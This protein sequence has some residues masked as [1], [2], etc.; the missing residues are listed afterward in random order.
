MYIYK[1]AKQYNYEKTHKRKCKY[2]HRYKHIYIKIIFIGEITL[3]TILNYAPNYTLHPKLFERT[4][5]ILNYHTLHLGVTF[6]VMFN[7]ILLHVTNICFLLMWNKL[8]RLKHPSSKS[9]K[10]KANFSTSLL[11]AWLSPN[12]NS[13]KL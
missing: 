7:E 6:A 3:F 12:S 13:C 2:K 10:T 9:I 5:C 11:H 4:L 1:G 8:K